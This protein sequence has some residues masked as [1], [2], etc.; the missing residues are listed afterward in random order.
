M[1]VQD[2]VALRK[3]LDLTQTEMAGRIGLSMR[4]YQDIEAGASKL[5]PIHAL[6]AERAALALAVERGNPMLAP[7]SVRRQALDLAR[8]ITGDDTP[9]TTKA[10]PRG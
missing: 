10:A 7:A 8:L 9:Q 5:R 3:L 2:L 4:G 6:A 1:T